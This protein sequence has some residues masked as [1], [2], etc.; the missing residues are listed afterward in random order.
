MVISSNEFLQFTLCLEKV[1]PTF[2]T[3]TWKPISRF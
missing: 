3:V 1:S 2:S